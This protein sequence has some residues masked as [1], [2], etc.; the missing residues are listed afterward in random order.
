MV[1]TVYNTKDQNRRFWRAAN[2]I[3]QKIAKIPGVVG[4]IAAG[5]IGRGHSDE[6]S[7]LDLIVYAMDTKVKEIAKIISMQ[8]LKVRR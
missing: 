1:E 4:V 8:N 5:G 3:S 7:D 2:I 6:F